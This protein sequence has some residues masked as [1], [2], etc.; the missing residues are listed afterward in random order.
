MVGGQ[1]REYFPRPL[2]YHSMFHI[3]QLLVQPSFRTP[4][5]HRLDAEYIWLQFSFYDVT[6]PV[7]DSAYTIAVTSFHTPSDIADGWLQSL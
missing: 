1:A 4:P 3:L 5:N 6:F 2:R 7:S